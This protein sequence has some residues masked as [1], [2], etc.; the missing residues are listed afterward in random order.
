[1]TAAAM[2]TAAVTAAAPVAAPPPPC[3]ANAGDIEPNATA[4]ATAKAF[5]ATPLN[6]PIDELSGV[7]TAF[8]DPFRALDKTRLN[9]PT[10]AAERWVGEC[11]P[12]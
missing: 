3:P 1:M 8:L 12:G 4:R 6:V 9:L 5:G 2:T 11:S 10:S 7:R